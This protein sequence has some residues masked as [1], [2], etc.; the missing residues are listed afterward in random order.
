VSTPAD[1]CECGAHVTRFDIDAP[2]APPLCSH[3]LFLP[4]W[5]TNPQLRHIVGPGVL[6]PKDSCGNG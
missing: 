1:C 6:D 2:P 4:G 5:H 3:C